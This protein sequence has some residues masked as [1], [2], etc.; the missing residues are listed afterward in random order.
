MLPHRISTVQ[1]KRGCQKGLP[2]RE[3]VAGVT[4]VELL[5]VI[6]VIVILVALLM[7]AIGVARASARQRQCSSNLTQIF[8]G[9]TRGNSR[10]ARQPIRG[11]QWTEGVSA[12]LEGNTQ[13]LFCPDD[14]DRQSSSSY[15]LNSRA[16]LFG[17]QDAGRIVMLDFKAT[18]ALMVGPTFSQLESAWQ[19]H[20][21]PRHFQKHN[22]LFYDG[23]ASAC[24]TSKIDPRDCDTFVGRWR[25]HALSHFNLVG[26][27]PGGAA[28]SS[29]MPGPATSG[30]ATSSGATGSTTVLAATTTTGTT[31][32]PTTTT[33]PSSSSTSTTTT[34]GSTTLATTTTGGTTTGGTTTGGTTTG[35]T[36]TYRVLFSQTDVNTQLLGWE[37]CDNARFPSDGTV[38]VLDN[39]NFAYAGRYC[40]K[41]DR[42]SGS[43][44]AMRLHNLFEYGPDCQQ[45]GL[46]KETTTTFMVRIP[47]AYTF[48]WLMLFGWK[49]NNK[50]GSINDPTVAIEFDGNVGYLRAN[51]KGA[52]PGAANG[53]PNNIYQYGP[54]PKNPA[55][56]NNVPFPID[57]W[58]KIDFYVKHSTGSDGRL[59]VYQDGTL[60]IAY[61]GRTMRESAPNL[62]A[63]LVNYG[64]GNGTT[65]Y[66][67]SFELRTP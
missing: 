65:V 5:I 10:D 20:Q 34:T 40:L 28:A 38:T 29:P 19:T 3:R 16:Q 37:R 6:A 63:Q 15:G 41:S 52:N 60:I 59:R 56:K 67:D 11:A 49:Q 22:V 42:P 61:D 2:R 35:G 18:E 13:V 33:G 54:N 45:T 36:P 62:E 64:T 24:D 55:E 7:P 57:K 1:V 50:P 30:T 46:P 26:C 58:V 25:P 21:A 31:A 8:N 27:I 32:A 39:P 47:Q 23:H 43:N 66:Y 44:T 14:F 48:D 12:Y 17:A 53:S 51:I 9:W 4:L